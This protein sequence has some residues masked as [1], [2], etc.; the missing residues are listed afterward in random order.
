MKTSHVSTKK[1]TEGHGGL[2]DFD[3]KK[4][5]SWNKLKSLPVITF[6]PPPPPPSVNAF[7]Q[8]CIFSPGYNPL[9][10]IYKVV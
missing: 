2:D 5:C 6:L 7:F 8:N 4:D 9:K 10:F 3:D 1:G